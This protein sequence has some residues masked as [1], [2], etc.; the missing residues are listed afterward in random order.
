MLRVVGEIGLLLSNGRLIVKDQ[1]GPLA[2]L[3]TGDPSSASLFVAFFTENGLQG[4]LDNIP[5]LVVLVA[6]EDDS[7]ADLVVAEGA[8]ANK[9]W[10]LISSRD[11]DDRVLE[12]KAMTYNEVGVCKMASLTICSIL[13]SGTD[14]PLV[15]W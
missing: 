7:S 10:P 15:S 12:T 4:V 2:S 11:D 3:E 14:P 6:K 13:E 9:G 5:K 8:R 1:N